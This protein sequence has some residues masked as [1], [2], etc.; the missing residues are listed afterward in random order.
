MRGRN[1]NTGMIEE[2]LFEFFIA[3]NNAPWPEYSTVFFIPFPPEGHLGCFQVLKNHK[4]SFFK[5]LSSDFCVDMF[6]TLLGKY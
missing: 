4:Q 5:F 1:Y 2:F 6:S 3:L